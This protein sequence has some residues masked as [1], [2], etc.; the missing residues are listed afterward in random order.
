MTLQAPAG[1]YKFYCYVLLFQLLIQLHTQICN[2]LNHHLL[3]ND[4]ATISHLPLFQ[5]LQCGCD[6]FRIHWPFHCRRSDIVVYAKLQHS[7]LLGMARCG[8]SLNGNAFHKQSE[9]RNWGLAEVDCEGIDSASCGHDWEVPIRV[10][11]RVHS[12]RI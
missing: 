8:R 1:N 4:N 11:L 5:S 7:H 9:K 3:S 6:S 2:S 12:S 10:S